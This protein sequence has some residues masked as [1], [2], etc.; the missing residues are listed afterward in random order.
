MTKGRLLFV[1]INTQSGVC[2]CVS[3]CA[4]ACLIDGVSLFL[5]YLSCFG[6]GLVGFFF[7]FFFLS[8]SFF[9]SF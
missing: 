3:V 4:C 1:K 9:W 7:P 6:V 5:L 2:V 8:L